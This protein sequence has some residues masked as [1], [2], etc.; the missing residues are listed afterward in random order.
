MPVRVMVHTDYISEIWQHRVSALEVGW[1]A[2]RQGVA[3]VGKGGLGNRRGARREGWRRR[4]KG[5]EKRGRHGR[6]GGR[7]RKRRRST[8]LPQGKPLHLC[9][10]VGLFLHRL[11]Q[12]GSMGFLLP[13]ERDFSASLAFMSY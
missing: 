10:L 6:V 13:Y 7:E 5:V 2:R 8:E 11:R 3:V 12:I 4:E 1:L 9:C